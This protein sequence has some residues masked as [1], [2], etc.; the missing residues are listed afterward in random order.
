MTHVDGQPLLGSL[1]TAS[2]CLEQAGD[3]VQLRI[4]PSDNST[5]VLNGNVKYRVLQHHVRQGDSVETIAAQHGTTTDQIRSDNRRHFPVGE[6]GFLC[7]GHT[8][9]VR[10]TTF[11]GASCR[12]GEVK[13][14]AREAN[15]SK[16]RRR[17]ILYDV[18]EGDSLETICARLRV[19]EAEVRRCNRQVF[20]VGEPGRLTPGQ[21]LT[22]FATECN[23]F[24][25]NG[26][27]HP[28]I[29]SGEMAGLTRAFGSHGEGIVG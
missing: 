12:R 22:V 11:S 26:C 1:K 5:T 15:S 23:A 16:G 28:T 25:E 9:T 8:L 17:Q 27:E 21:T 10:A 13:P 7:P 3:T 14:L 2:R 29:G 20:P 18:R 4:R 19:E 24:A 6:P